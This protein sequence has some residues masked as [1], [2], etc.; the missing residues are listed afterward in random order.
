MSAC[1]SDPLLTLADVLQIRWLDLVIF[2]SFLTLNHSLFVAQIN[3][4]L[5]VQPVRP[6]WVEDLPYRI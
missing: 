6:F 1:M 3:S 4:S 5:L 2:F